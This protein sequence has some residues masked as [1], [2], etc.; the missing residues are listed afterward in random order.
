MTTYNEIASNHELVY[1]GEEE[2]L[3]CIG[4]TPISL[5]YDDDTE[6][7]W[8]LDGYEPHDEVTLTI[9]LPTSVIPVSMFEEGYGTIQNVSGITDIGAYAFSYIKQSRDMRFSGVKTVG[10]YAFMGISSV[11]NIIF[12]SALKSIGNGA[13]TSMP[14]GRDCIIQINSTSPPVI[15]T[16]VFDSEVT[17]QVPTGY[18]DTYKAAWP[19]YA[20]QIQ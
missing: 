11:Q 20:R 15:G 9:Y 18:A 5:S 1:K 8:Y 7:G 2:Y 12:D 3:V 16:N 10:N 6:P 19:D 13:F 14:D 4:D 17:I